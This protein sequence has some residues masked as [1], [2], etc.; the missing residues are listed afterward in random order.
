MGYDGVAGW[1]VLAQGA[2][3]VR[4]WESTGALAVEH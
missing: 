3:Q 1:S 4:I 2:D